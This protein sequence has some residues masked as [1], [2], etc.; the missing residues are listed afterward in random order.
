MA[1]YPFKANTDATA[2]IGTAKF[3]M[4]TQD[5]GAWI[6]NVAEESQMIE[7]MRKGGDLTVHGTSGHGTVSTDTYSLK[8]LVQALDR[9]DQECK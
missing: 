3:A 9:A 4:Q 6:R 8:G 7:A 5:D 2:Q 1:G